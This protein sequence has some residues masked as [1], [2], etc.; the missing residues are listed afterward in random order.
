M[1]PSYRSEGLVG[2]VDPTEVC[3]DAD[4][5]GR[6]E[7]ENLAISLIEHEARAAWVRG[8]AAPRGWCLFCHGRCSPVA[9]YCDPDCRDDHEAEQRALARQGR[10]A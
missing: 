8:I 7:A 5:A 4:L 6:R 3:D 9:V 2:E 1:S 10:V